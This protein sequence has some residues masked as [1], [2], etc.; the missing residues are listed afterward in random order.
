M[1]LA[2]WIE[3]PSEPKELL[4]VWQAPPSVADRLRWA[5]GRLRRIGDGAEFDYLH[6]DEFAALNLGRS[7]DA[8]RGAGY[9]GYPA[10]DTKKRPEGGFRDRALEAFLRR[11]PPATR[12][13][14]ANYLAHYHIRQTA[15]LSPFALLAVTEARL[16]SDG[17]SLVD[18]LDASASCVDL[19]FEIAG[20]RHSPRGDAGVAIGDPLQLEPEPSNRWDSQ[21]IQ[22]NAAG[23]IIGYVNRLQAKTILR[24]LEERVVTCW[25][26]RLNGRPESPRA[27]AFLQVRPAECSV[28]A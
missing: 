18:P 15:L 5:V 6:G 20:F 23:R 9:S 2:C 7:P 4:L 27:Y 25:I 14:F 22:V 13:D 26:T 10:F 1:T 21:A 17:F 24:W 16:P 12:S 8:L 28:A 11:V 3:Y 19:I